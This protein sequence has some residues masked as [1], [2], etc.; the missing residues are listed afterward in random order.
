[1]PLR[2]LD[3][4]R[5]C[6]QTSRFTSTLAENHPLGVGEFFVAAVV[7]ALVDQLFRSGPVRRVGSPC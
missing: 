2:N 3:R 7:A 1:M 5:H 4:L 6:W